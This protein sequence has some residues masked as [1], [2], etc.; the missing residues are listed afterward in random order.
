[1][2]LHAVRKRDARH[3]AIRWRPRRKSIEPSFRA[4]GA[5][6]P[7]P[8]H[9]N[10]SET[11][12]SPQPPV[13]PPGARFNFAQHLIDR[14]AG[15]QAKTAYI[16]DQGRLGYG[17]LADRIRRIAA[18]LLALGVRREERVLLLMHDCNDWPVS[19][20]LRGN[21]GLASGH[22]RDGSGLTFHRHACKG[23]IH[24]APKA[25]IARR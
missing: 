13:P 4:G 15:R 8:K 23:S 18:A 16:D 20:R 21:E 11:R 3:A 2:H 7:L 25:C 22:K 12:M 17:D 5:A 9:E 10:E 6:G 19:S 24:A 1:M 14:N